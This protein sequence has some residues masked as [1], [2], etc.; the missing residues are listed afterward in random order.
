MPDAP[1][2]AFPGNQEENRQKIYRCI[3]CGLDLVLTHDGRLVLCAKQPSGIQESAPT[4]DEPATTLFPILPKSS[5]SREATRDFATGQT[6]PL[7]CWLKVVHTVWS[8]R[9]LVGGGRLRLFTLAR[10]A[11]LNGSSDKSVGE[12]SPLWIMR[13]RAR[14]P[15]AGDGSRGS[16][17]GKASLA[18]AR[19][20]IEALAEMSAIREV[21]GRP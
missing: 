15:M 20:R 16:P 21:E 17:A 10:Q 3:V 2:T 11:F 1:G 7:H 9:A 19:A 4:G 8:C 13:T 14:H 18:G 12:P 5:E 6:R